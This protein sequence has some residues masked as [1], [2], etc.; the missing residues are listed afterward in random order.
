M[1]HCIFCIL[2]RLSEKGIQQAKELNNYL[3]SVGP[4]DL[5]VVSPLIRTLQTME[6]AFN[7]I[8]CKKIVN[9]LCREQF[10]IHLCDCWKDIKETK[11]MFKDVDFSLI[12]NECDETRFMTEREPRTNLDVR[13][14]EFL[15]WLCKRDEER[16]GV[17]S[18]ISF[19]YL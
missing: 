10:G 9:P 3:K 5:I 6:N 16:M 17:V 13:G 14:K 2:N 19:L 1:I 18:H 4:F 7:G 15:E 8:N 12:T 11:E